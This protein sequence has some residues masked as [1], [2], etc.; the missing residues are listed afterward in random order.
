MKQIAVLSMI[1]LMVAL[2][3][4]PP[5]AFAQSSEAVI[6]QVTNIDPTTEKITIKHGPIKKFGMDEGMTMVFRVLDPQL[7]KSRRDIGPRGFHAPLYW[8]PAI[9]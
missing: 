3:A 9:V 2:G 1:A 4:A 7:L 5:A 8:L 6:G